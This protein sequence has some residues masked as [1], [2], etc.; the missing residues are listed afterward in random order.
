[1]TTRNV[2]VLS[3]SALLFSALLIASCSPRE[4]EGLIA[5]WKF[6]E[7]KGAKLLDSSGHCNHGTIHG[8][9][10][11]EGRVGT[12]LRFDGVDDYV[13]VPKSASLNSISKEI[14][15]MCWIR[16]PLTDRY[17]ILERWLCSGSYRRQR[18]LELDV[19]SE[20]KC[21]NFALSPDGA[22]GMWHKRRESI[23]AGRWVHI[24]ATSDGRVMKVY[25]NGEPDPSPLSLNDPRIHQS[26]SDLHIGVWYSGNTWSC[27]FKG[28][29]DDIRI[30]SRALTHEEIL[31]HYRKPRPKGVIAGKVFDVNG[32]PVRGASVRT[33][34]FRTTTDREGRYKITVPA[35]THQLVISKK[36]Y[37]RGRKPDV[38]VKEGETTEVDIALTE[39]RIAPSISEV[40][41]KDV[42]DINAAV[43]WETDEAC[44]GTLKYGTSSGKYDKVAEGTS[45][46]KSHRIILAGLTPN[47]KYYFTVESKDKGENTVKSKEQTFS[48]LATDN[49]Q[50]VA[51]RTENSMKVLLKH[52]DLDRPGLEKVKASADDPVKA[53][54]ELLA[55][56]RARKSVKHFVNRADRKKSRGKYATARDLKIADDALEHIFKGSD[57]GKDI[58][59]ATNPVPDHEWI[60]A[61][62]RMHFWGAMAKAYWHTGDEKYAREWCF[63]LRDWVRKNPVDRKY[64]YT[65][66]PWRRI[67]AGMRGRSWM[68]LYQRFLDSP[69][70]TPEVLVT[71]LN[72]CYD[73]ASFLVERFTPRNHG[74]FEAEGVGFIAIMFPEFKDARTWR[75]KVIRHQN[76]QIKIQVRPDGHQIEQAINYHAACLRLFSRTHELAKMNGLTGALD[77]RYASRLE[78]MAEVLMK[79][80]LPDGSSAQF[81]D[82]SSPLKIRTRLAKWAGVFGR[83]DFLY[84]ATAGKEGTKPKQTAYALT[85]SGFYSMRSGWDEKAICLVLK[86]GPG[87]FWH[88][89]PDNGTFELYA[90]GRRLM[91]DSGTFI[92]HGDPAGRR[93]FR[94]TRVHQ[95]LTLD[96][97]NTEY[98]PAL[99]LWKPGKDLDVLVVEN[100]SYENLTHRRAVMFVKK[101][102]F[103]LVDEA[104]GKAEGNVDLHFQLA[105][106]E[107]VF[108]RKAPL[109]RTDFDKG[110]NVLIRGLAQKPMAL[111]KE[112][113]QVSFKYGQK[114]P[115]PAFRFRIKKAAETPAVRFITLVVPHEGVVPET[116]VSLVG[117]PAPGASRIE[118]DVTVGSVTARIGYDLKKKKAWIR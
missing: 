89:Q 79:L 83:K 110:A 43:G 47:T 54:K 88:C 114:Q 99:R 42:D 41:I 5:C 57:R 104:I 113:G 35:G 75:D 1:M 116:K 56:Y 7:G 46:V 25:V 93:W 63:Q 101:K 65:V 109:V 48:T 91:P 6:E 39:D 62:H 69:S 10:W 115:R 17:T 12:G 112:K 106:G 64:H 71:F 24:A 72:S 26:T 9:T 37:R 53:A 68:E 98:K 30:Y 38:R 18:C 15:L 23:P 111:R 50:L 103:V 60:W 11:V 97:K 27:F 102:F 67:E 8:A 86:C 81:G 90:A 14:T 108:D 59:W 44:T 107:A 61:L 19:D 16:S 94:Q 80:S 33:G 55:Y 77:D 20:G 52:L 70:F 40:K 85:D 118:L 2:A 32:K 82:T 96:G 76:D 100:G 36:G 78:K 31:E 22:S 84:V 49:P 66:T 117:S 58:D 92:Y 21:V 29:M 87:P 3:L 34:L 4:R 95:T 45:Y 13:Q 51:R 73:H 74:L 105:P 28:I